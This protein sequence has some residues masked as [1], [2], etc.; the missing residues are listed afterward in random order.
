[1]SVLTG[2]REFEPRPA[3]FNSQEAHAPFEIRNCQSNR[4]DPRPRR[5]RRRLLSQYHYDH[6][7]HDHYPDVDLDDAR[8]YYV[9]N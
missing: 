2:L 6:H 1:M 7:D 3:G 9:D 4:D 8:A 5:I